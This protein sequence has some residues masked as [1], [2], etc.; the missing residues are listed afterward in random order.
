MRSADDEVTS[1]II[2]TASRIY[3]R[4]SFHQRRRLLEMR[5]GAISLPSRHFP[6]SI[7]SPFLLHFP[8]FCFPLYIP[9]FP[10]APVLLPLSPSFLFSLFSLPPKIHR[11]SGGALESPPAGPGAAWTQNDFGEAVFH[12]PISPFFVL[13]H[14]LLQIRGGENNGVAP[15][16]IRRLWLSLR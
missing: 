1:K 8:F 16:G 3:S 10:F 2:A 12:L 4:C 9:S 14:T 11:W 5:M 7:P 6:S 15:N 13:L